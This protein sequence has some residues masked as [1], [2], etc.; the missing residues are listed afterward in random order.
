MITTWAIHRAGGTCL[1]LHPTS[2]AAE[3][4]AHLKRAK[5]NVIFTNH[6]LVATAQKAMAEP[7]A[8]IY[9][10]EMPEDSLDSRSANSLQLETVNEMIIRGRT[11]PPLEQIKLS[12]GESRERVAYLCPTSGTSGKQV[13]RL[14]VFNNFDLGM[15]T[16]KKAGRNL[17]N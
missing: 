5:C 1:L 13:S 9:V 16:D 2:S 14:T 7:I 4:E 11:L 12:P 15:A 6:R 10:L 3:I 17:R 8:K